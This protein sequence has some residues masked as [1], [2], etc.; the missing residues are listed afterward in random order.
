MVA[1]SLSFSY[2]IINIIAR[3]FII[4]HMLFKSKPQ[5]ELKASLLFKGSSH[6]KKTLKIYAPVKCTV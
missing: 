1:K 4:L 2:K 6:E 5:Q 3:V